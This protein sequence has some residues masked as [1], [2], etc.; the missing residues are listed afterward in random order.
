MNT[1]HKQNLIAAALVSALVFV[2][3]GVMMHQHH[4][5]FAAAGSRPLE[6]LLVAQR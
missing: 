3:T 2:A 4:Q 1:K 5:P 6:H